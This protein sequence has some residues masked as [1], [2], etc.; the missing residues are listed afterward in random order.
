MFSREAKDIL[1][2]RQTTLTGKTVGCILSFFS[3]NL[4]SLA[5]SSDLER[6]IRFRFPIRDLQAAMLPTQL[7]KPTSRTTNI[8][9]EMHMQ[10]LGTCNGGGGQFQDLNFLNKL[11][12]R[13]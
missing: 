8:I 2:H 5:T 3:R 10:W 6:K 13:D 7:V 11:A 9:Q 4:P 1:Q 12:K